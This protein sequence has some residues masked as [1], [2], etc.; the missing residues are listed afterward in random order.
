VGSAHTL[1]YHERIGRLDPVA[2]V[3]G[4]PPD[5]AKDPA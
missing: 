2:H 3:H 4:Q 5:D 1:R